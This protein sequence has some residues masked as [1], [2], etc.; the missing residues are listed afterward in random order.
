MPQEDL[1][2]GF[3]ALPRLDLPPGRLVVPEDGGTP[4]Y[5]LSDEP[6][7]PALWVRLHMAH[8]Q[9]GLWPVLTD[10]HWSDPRRPWE[11]GEVWPQPRPLADIDHLDA[12]AVLEGFWRAH[13]NGEHLLLEPVGDDPREMAG[14]I[15]T[16]PRRDFPEL[17]PFGRDWPGLAPGAETGRDPDEFADWYL[18]RNDDGTSRIALVPA[19]RSADVITAAGWMGPCNYTNNIPLLSSVVRSWET[20]FGARVIEIGFD[21]L[22][23]VV[24]APPAVAEHAERVAAEHFAFCPDNVHEGG[25]IING[26]LLAYPP[27]IGG[28]SASRV[29]GKE[30]WWFWWD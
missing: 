30:E 22:R 18:P 23:L 13:A 3:D 4:G 20:R 21:C 19:A 14:E 26:A 28:Y 10:G 17:G 12:G 29:L 16:D 24:A 6:A 25:L 5:W 9:S 1:P 27:T 7:D 8:S 15:R 11:A 2:T